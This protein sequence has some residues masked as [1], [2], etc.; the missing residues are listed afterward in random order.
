MVK[1][2]VVVGT[3]TAP[4]RAHTPDKN[5]SLRG[6]LKKRTPLSRTTRRRTRRRRTRRTP[7][8][9]RAAVIIR[10][11]GRFSDDGFRAAHLNHDY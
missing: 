9:A 6:V 5:A 4:Q 8:Q 10:M 1:V 7:S 2:V 3:V 11:R